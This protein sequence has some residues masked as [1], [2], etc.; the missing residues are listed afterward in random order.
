M[1]SKIRLFSCCGVSLFSV[2]RF[3]KVVVVVVL[4]EVDVVVDGETTVLFLS[5]IIKLFSCSDFSSIAEVEILLLLKKLNKPTKTTK[6]NTDIAKF[7][8]VK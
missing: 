7:L 1:V 2:I 4:V 5:S 3:G 6:L 8:F